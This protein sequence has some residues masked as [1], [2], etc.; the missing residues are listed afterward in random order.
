MAKYYDQNHNAKDL[1]Q[2]TDKLIALYLE[3]QTHRHNLGELAKVSLNMCN[4]FV[5]KR[6]KDE[7][8]DKPIYFISHTDIDKFLDSFISFEDGEYGNKR[9]IGATNRDSHKRYIGA[10]FKWVQRTHNTALPSNPMVN[11]RIVYA[12]KDDPKAYTPDAVKTMLDH[13]EDAIIPYMAVQL[14]GG[15]RSHEATLIRWNDISWNTNEISLS[16]EITKTGRS[17]ILTM[18]PNLI[19]ILSTHCPKDTTSLLCSIPL[20]SIERKLR[21]IRNENNI[22]SI[23]SG[24]RHSFCTYSLA[25]YKLDFTMRN[26]GHTSSTTLLKYYYA[27]ALN[28]EPDAERYFALGL[29]K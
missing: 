15:A 11:T 23:H 8:K 20:K 4:H 16:K 14:F 18:K 6:F 27:P 2:N 26:S 9:K 7:F 25:K 1:S 12:K 3:H 10:F 29:N 19:R 17:R 13:A 5:G 21:T 22:E 24:F 28:R